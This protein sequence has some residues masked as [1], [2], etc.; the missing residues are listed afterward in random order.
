[1]IK[2]ILKR[3]GRTDLAD[4]VELY[5]LID[6]VPE[7]GAKVW[8]EGTEFIQVFGS[9]LVQKYVKGENITKA[10]KNKVKSEMSQFLHAA[11]QAVDDLL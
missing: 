9:A 8:K 4:L 6:T 7:Q 2:W 11:G 1:M 5:S 3:A 10:Q